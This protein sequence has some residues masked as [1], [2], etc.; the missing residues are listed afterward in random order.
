MV[1]T[2]IAALSVITYWRET[3]RISGGEAKRKSA[4][5]CGISGKLA[6]KKA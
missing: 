1:Q 3:L 2:G 4:K 5:A 6:N